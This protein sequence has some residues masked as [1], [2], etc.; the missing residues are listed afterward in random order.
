MSGGGSR[1]PGPRASEAAITR[2]FRG[3]GSSRSRSFARSADRDPSFADARYAT[4][5]GWREAER[6]VRCDWSDRSF[7]TLF[8]GV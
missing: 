8:V 1:R 4:G 6:V 3:T 5:G 2:A 7:P